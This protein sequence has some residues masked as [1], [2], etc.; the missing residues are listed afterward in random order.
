M[1]SSDI[2]HLLVEWSQGNQ[3][4]FET[5]LPIVERDLH[6]IAHRFMRRMQPGNTLQTT[7]L[8]NETYLRLIDQKKVVWQNRA[9]FYGIA[10][11]I[12]R[13][14]FCLITYEIK[15]GKREVE[16]PSKYRFPNLL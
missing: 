2:T 15:N 11:R 14:F 9:H 7:A 5:L 10:A 8:I 13:R 4:A 1:N 12:M 6:Q 16:T 3:Q